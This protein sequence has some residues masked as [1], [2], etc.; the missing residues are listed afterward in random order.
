MKKFRT[1]KFLALAL[2]LWHGAGLFLML[3]AL[4]TLLPQL[5]RGRG[6]R[7]RQGLHKLS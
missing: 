7:R 6:E 1:A 2:T 4:G 3:G 5:P